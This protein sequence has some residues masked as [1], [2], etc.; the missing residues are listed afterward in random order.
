MFFF[1]HVFVFR[2]KKTKC[3]KKNHV[4]SRSLKANF[5]SR[6]V[7]LRGKQATFIIDK[8]VGRTLLK[9]N[10]NACKHMN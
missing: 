1:Q 4:V 10:N 2:G 7:C 3:G 8:F 5:L 9:K 6:A